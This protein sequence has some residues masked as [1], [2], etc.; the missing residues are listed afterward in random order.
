MSVSKIFGKSPPGGDS[1]YFYK[2]VKNIM[3]KKRADNW[4]ENGASLALWP[5]PDD[6]KL[7]GEI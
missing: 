1:D 6:R 4:S 3:A 5:Y 2:S 7:W